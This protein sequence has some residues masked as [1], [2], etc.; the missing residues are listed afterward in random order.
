MRPVEVIYHIDEYGAAFGIPKA[1][2]G[3]TREQIEALAEETNY[4]KR[5]GMQPA[6]VVLQIDEYGAEFGVPAAYLGLTRDQIQALAEEYAKPSTRARYMAGLDASAW[7]PEAGKS[8]A[9]RKPSAKAARDAKDA[10]EA[11]RLAKLRKATPSVLAELPAKAALPGERPAGEPETLVERAIRR[12]ARLSTP[13]RRRAAFLHHFSRCRTV[14]EAAARTGIDGR[15]VRRWRRDVP[16][17]AARCE[18]IVIERRREAIETVVMAADQA[19]TQ[20]VFYRGAKVGEYTRRDRTLGLYLLKQAD[21]AALRAEQRREAAA[22]EARVQ[23]EVAQRISKMS[24]SGGHPEARTPGLSSSPASVLAPP[25]R[26]SPSRASV[27]ESVRSP[28][29]P[30][31][32]TIASSV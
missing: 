4:S 30:A 15:T 32:E 17:F 23:A 24:A 28:A 31:P 14:V 8:Y 9:E 3:M 11:A 27:P 19:E 5:S 13:A 2:G 22:F 29:A 6:D 18:Q 20:P 26:T 25:N 10:R 16:A 21:A 12:Q 1:Y 7:P